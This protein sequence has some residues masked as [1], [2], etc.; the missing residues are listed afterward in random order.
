MVIISSL[1]TISVS[2]FMRFLIDDYIMP[3]VNSSNPDFSNLLSMLIKMGIFLAIGVICSSP[4]QD[5]WL[6]Y[7]NQ[8]LGK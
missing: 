4:T 6:Q 8:L 3:L 7:L 1:A 2:L 5:L